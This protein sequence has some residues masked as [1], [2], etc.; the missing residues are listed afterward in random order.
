MQRRTVWL[1]SNPE[2]Y[3]VQEVEFI[4]VQMTKPSVLSCVPMGL[5]LQEGIDTVPSGECPPHYGDRA[6][7]SGISLAMAFSDCPR[8][9]P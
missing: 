5:R 1:M 7:V 4:T 8:L 2:G 3:R 6:P 9:V